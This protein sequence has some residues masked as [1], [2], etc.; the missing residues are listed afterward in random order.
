MSTTEW[1]ITGEEL[2]KL[3]GDIAWKEHNRYFVSEYTPYDVDDFIQELVTHVYEKIAKGHIPDKPSVA[4]EWMKQRASEY[5]LETFDKLP[6]YENE[7]GEKK[8]AIRLSIEEMRENL[9]ENEDAL[10][11][12]DEYTAQEFERVDDEANS[13]DLT[14]DTNGK[15]I[16]FISQLFEFLQLEEFMPGREADILGEGIR[17]QDW[18]AG[19]SQFLWNFRNRNVKE[20]IEYRNYPDGTLL[21]FVGKDYDVRCYKLMNEGDYNV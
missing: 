3:A 14:T 11:I 18:G 9:F 6:Q 15:P 5:W 16:P 7:Y 17:T 8:P 13:I 21:I 4:Y 1:E 2:L 20:N 19:A 10:D 12:E